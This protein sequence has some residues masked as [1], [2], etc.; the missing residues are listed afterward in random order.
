[1][2]PVY[3]FHGNGRRR[4]GQDRGYRN[5]YKDNNN[6][7]DRDRKHEFTFRYPRQHF[8]T[9]ERPLLRTN[10]E[11][12]AELLIRPPAGGGKKTA[13]RFAPIEEL[14]DSE[15]E[16]MDLSN[17]D[18]DN[19]ND[20]E[21]QPPPLAPSAPKWSNPDPYTVLPP[22]GSGESRGKK[23]DVVKLIRKA[24]VET[25]GA[26]K[27]EPGKDAVASNDDFISFGDVEE[28]AGL[29]R[30]P[31]RSKPVQKYYTDGS[32]IDEWRKPPGEQGTPWLDPAEP[33]LHLGTRF[34]PSFS[35]FFFSCH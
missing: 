4:N 9:S 27:S 15:E 17:S 14:D 25:T 32:I 7:Y 24:R 35:F 23:L 16:D 13:L 12:E 22:P 21:P 26:E 31:K 19:D 5:N 34:V 18:D 10:T 3:R 2:P 6:N 29:P 28:A 11:I 33:A 8:G 20:D 30:S 1:M